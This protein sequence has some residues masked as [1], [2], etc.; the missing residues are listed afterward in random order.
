MPRH[1]TVNNYLL[2]LS[3]FVLQIN[4]FDHNDIEIYLYLPVCSRIRSRAHMHAHTHAC[5]H[6][7]MHASAHTH[8]EICIVSSNQQGNK[9]IRVISYQ[10]GD[11]RCNSKGESFIDLLARLLLLCYKQTSVYTCL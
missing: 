9:V 4:V 3:T 11:S 5:T 2:K 1:L 6:A 8:I 7:R 10:Q